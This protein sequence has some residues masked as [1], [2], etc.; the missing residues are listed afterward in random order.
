MGNKF[1]QYY[2]ERMF[3]AD[4]TEFVNWLNNG[5]KVTIIQHDINDKGAEYRRYISVWLIDGK[6]GHNGPKKCH[7]MIAALTNGKTVR[8]GELF[9]V[10]NVDSFV[11]E[12]C[13]ELKKNGYDL[14]VSTDPGIRTPK[15]GW[16]AWDNTYD[17]VA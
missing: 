12:I 1:N 4:C 8:S 7:N 13:E 14:H 17:F 2:T 16:Y 9:S 5:K 6:R 10:N 11:W 3:R 15:Y